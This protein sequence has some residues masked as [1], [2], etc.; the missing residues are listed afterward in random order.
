MSAATKAYLACVLFS[1]A[2]TGLSVATGLDPGPIRP[3]AAAATLLLG[4]AALLAAPLRALGAARALGGA[5]LVLAVGAASE[6]AGLYTG[7]PFGRYEYTERWQPVLPLPGG[8]VF[9]VLLPFA[10]FLVAGACYLWVS[11]WMTGWAAAL[12]GALLAAAV[13]AAMEPVMTG[14]LGYWRW[15]EPTVLGIAPAANFGGWVGVSLLAGLILGRFGFGRVGSPA[16]AGWV[17][18]GHLSLVGAIAALAS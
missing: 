2:G 4:V 11:R 1:I 17:L 7:F 10:W 18:A 12:A 15:L 14:P 3:L 6:V 5:G 16:D 13:D 9:P 8:H